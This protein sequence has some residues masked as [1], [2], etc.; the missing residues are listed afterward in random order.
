LNSVTIYREYLVLADFIS[1]EYIPRYGTARS[2]GIAIV[3]F[4]GDNI[5]S[6]MVCF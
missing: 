5:I 3:S 1:F 6:H 4:V 2:C